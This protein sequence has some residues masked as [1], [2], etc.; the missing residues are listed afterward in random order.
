MT[1]RQHRAVGPLHVIHSGRCNS[2]A[3]A[4]RST[5]MAAR[6][7]QRRDMSLSSRNMAA[8]SAKWI[9][10]TPFTAAGSRRS[11]ARPPREIAVLQTCDHLGRAGVGLGPRS[12]PRSW[13]VRAA[14]AGGVSHAC[15]IGLCG[16]CAPGVCCGGRRC[17]HS[18]GGDPW[19]DPGFA[20]GCVSSRSELVPIVADPRFVGLGRPCGGVSRHRGLLHASPGRR[21]QDH[22]E[23]PA[24]DHDV[25][26]RLRRLRL[27]P[28]RPRTSST[29]T[30]WCRTAGR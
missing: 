21:L 29:T 16:E 24:F 2:E 28:V 13:P 22:R 4:R 26:R 14:A 6:R 8:F 9:A 5:R 7:R 19:F 1:L 27:D 18:D 15:S 12:R 11:E 30:R 23:V 3:R 17:G 10:T 20:G 25:V